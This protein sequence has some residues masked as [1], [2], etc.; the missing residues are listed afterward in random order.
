VCAFELF[1]GLK[2]DAA[3]M[4]RYSG[5][6]LPVGEY[7]LETTQMIINCEALAEQ[8]NPHRRA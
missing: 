1:T 8:P 6:Q 4:Q 2:A 5:G 3:R 7:A